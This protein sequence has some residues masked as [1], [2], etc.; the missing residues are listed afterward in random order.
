M[1]KLLLLF[2]N[3]F[4][5]SLLGI[6]MLNNYCYEQ[7]FKGLRIR[8]ASV[9]FAPDPAHYMKNA[10][11]VHTVSENSGNYEIMYQ[12]RDQEKKDWTWRWSYP[13][14]AT[15]EMILHF[16]IPLTMFE[17]YYPVDSVIQARNRII[18]EGMFLMEGNYVGPDLNGMIRYYRPF[19]EPVAMLLDN[20]LGGNNTWRSRIELAMKFTQDIPYS[21]PPAE[22]GEKYTGGIFSP[23][24]VFVNMYGD[25]DSKVV[26]FAG[27]LAFY[28]DYEVLIL[29]ET[30]HIFTAVAGLPK[31]YDKFYEYQNK[32]YIMAETA[33]PGRYDLGVIKDPY[34]KINKAFL[35]EAE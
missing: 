19:L 17:P 25:C 35:V 2:I 24:Q 34:K 29:Q 10:H 31:P 6:V 22:Q 18:S 12:F 7:F 8:S 16:G 13:K 21:I 32:K 14:Q 23:P 20:T 5:L 33:G 27:I 26:I 1:G 15:D 9:Q 30:G 28:D 11:V 4:L 3:L